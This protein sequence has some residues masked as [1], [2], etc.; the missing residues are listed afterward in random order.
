MKRLYI[1]VRRDLAP[2]YQ[3]VQA[4]H[5]VAE[6]CRTHPHWDNEVLVYLHVRDEQHL[7]EV[8]AALTAGGDHITIFREGD[9][10]GQ[11][12]AFAVCDPKVKALVKRLPLLELDADDY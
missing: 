6:W 2:A 8:A 4:G 1:L 12:T 7:L 11:S 9:L 5:A 10:G 3:A